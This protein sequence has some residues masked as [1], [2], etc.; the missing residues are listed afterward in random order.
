MLDQ[1]PPLTMIQV[2]FIQMNDYSADSCAIS[3]M[4]FLLKVGGALDPHFL[5][6]D[7]SQKM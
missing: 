4:A 1:L 6:L 3:P 5:I 7:P 2:D